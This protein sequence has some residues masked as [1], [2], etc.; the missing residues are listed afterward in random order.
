MV[1]VLL[2]ILALL[3]WTIQDEL[4]SAGRDLPALQGSCGN[5]QA[6]VAADWIVCPHCQQRLQESCS[7]CHKGK[8]I[9]HPHCPFCG[10]GAGEVP[11]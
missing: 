8:L 10:D 4:E 1:L 7:S 9:S 2:L 6:T 3:L 11:G 5:C